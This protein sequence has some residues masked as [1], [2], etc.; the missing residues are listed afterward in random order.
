MAQEWELA[1]GDPRVAIA[2]GMEGAS[3]VLPEWDANMAP[4]DADV[5]GAAAF[6]DYRAGRLGAAIACLESYFRAIHRETDGESW[7]A[8]A[9]LLASLL[10]PDLSAGDLAHMIASDADVLRG[11]DASDRARVEA[12]L[13]TWQ[14]KHPGEDSP[15]LPW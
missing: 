10:D 13:A 12:A 6:Q 1:K 3:L 9:R 15:E 2:A 4:L 8:R 7:L 11:M 14:A 5:L